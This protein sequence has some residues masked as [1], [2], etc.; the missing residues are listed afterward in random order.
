MRDI[1]YTDPAVGWSDGVTWIGCG[2][3]S[4]C[5]SN[6]EVAVV[7][8]KP[9]IWKQ[10]VAM[11]GHFV[12]NL[13]SKNNKKRQYLKAFKGHSC[14]KRGCLH[15]FHEGQSPS[16]NDF[17]PLPELVAWKQCFQMVAGN[18]IQGVLHFDQVAV[19]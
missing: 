14:I 9:G 4:Y 12:L 17:N 1:F 8:M 6:F 10:E 16:S 11:K 15:F 3:S 18:G 7:F 2:A 5:A 19:K 13:G